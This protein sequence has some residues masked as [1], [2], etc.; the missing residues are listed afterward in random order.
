MKCNRICVITGTRAEYGLLRPLLFRLR[1]NEKV[2]LSLVVTGTHLMET[3]GNTQQEIRE[4]GFTNYEKVELP[5]MEDSKKAMVNATGVALSGFGEVYEKIK[6]ELVVVLGDRYEILAASIAAHFMGIPI[7]HLCGGDV[8]EGAVDDAIRHCITKLSTLHFPGCRQSAN[9]IIQMGEN[10]ERVFNV[11]EP[12]I[13]NCLHTELMTRKELSENLTFPAMLGA[14]G[15]VTFHPVTMEENTAKGQV[16]ELI[17]AMDE[18][19]NL[20]YIITLANADAGGR[21]I[22]EVW[23]EEGSKRKNWYVTPSLGMR[24][25]LS[26]VK[27]ADM[28]IGNSSS[29]LVE[30]PALNVPS[31]NIGDRQKGRMMAQSVISVPAE[32]AEISTAIK[33]ARS[34]QFHDEMKGM[35]LPFGNGTTSAQV[36]KTILEYLGRENRTTEKTFYDL[37]F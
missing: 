9:R 3:F 28:V 11:G 13:E 23:Q 32:E 22:N 34:A 4:D 18:Q 19:E 5:L 15:V 21:V 35:E 6:P 8:T 14:Y 27:Y 33:R 12:G 30:V 17:R 16:M 7:A 10:P 20:A 36:E 31:V 25:Y 37:E 26:A 29:A 1:D 24:R 2:E